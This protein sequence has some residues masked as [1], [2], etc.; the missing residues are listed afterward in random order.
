MLEFTV[1]RDERTST[2]YKGFVSYDGYNAVAAHHNLVIVT[3][4]DVTETWLC[5]PT[6]AALVELHRY[7][8]DRCEPFGRFLICKPTLAKEYRDGKL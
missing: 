6:D 7:Y 2:T 5:E 1:M 3:V 8:T 4:E